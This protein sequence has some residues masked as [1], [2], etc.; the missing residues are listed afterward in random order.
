MPMAVYDQNKTSGVAV[1]V[2]D[3]HAS[4]A[5]LMNRC[6]NEIARKIRKSTANWAV[7]NHAVLSVLQ[8][9][10]A[11]QFVRTT[12]GK[13][14]APTNNKQLGVLNGAIKVYVNTYATDDDI[15]MGYKGDNEIDAPAYY[16]PYIPVMCS[17][18]LIDPN[19]FENVM[20]M[21]TRYGFKAL[22]NPASSLGNAAD[23]LARIKVQ[24]LRFI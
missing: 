15:L 23:Y 14:E 5:A 8:S 11:S 9:A 6:G 16:C 19:T 13:F 17:G 10:G 21:V 12:E 22:T 24:N 7:V 3:E 1:S 2:V 20:G 4:L 18:T